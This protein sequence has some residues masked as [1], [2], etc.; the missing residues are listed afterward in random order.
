MEDHAADELD[1]EGAETEDAIGR[2]TSGQDAGLHQEGVE[3]GA[4][5]HLSLELC[6]LGAKLVVGKLGH[7]GANGVD[8]VD[9][10]L[11]ARLGL[12]RGV[13]RRC[14]CAASAASLSLS[15]KALHRR[16]APRTGLVARGA[17][18]L[19]PSDA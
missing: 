1:V 9:T 2:F 13:A 5:A 12:G 18:L 15:R 7:G 6:G 10:G 4:A 17:A 19:F 14:R 3:I 11:V 16:G 8:G